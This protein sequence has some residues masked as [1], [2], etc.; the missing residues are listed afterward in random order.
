MAYVLL[1]LAL[2]YGL[3]Q[4]GIQPWHITAMAEKAAY[5]GEII[6]EGITD[7][8]GLQ[9]KFEIV[10]KQVAPSVVAISAACTK[11]EADAALRSEDMSVQKLQA[12]LDHTTRIV[13]SGFVIDSNGYILTNE[14]V[15]G[16]AEQIWV[17]TD[18]KKIYPAIVVGSD[19]RADLA[20]LKIPAR[21]LPV[22]RFADGGTVRGQWTIALGNPYGLAAEGEMAMSVGIVSATNR[23]LPKLASKENRLYTN[24]IQTTAQINP[25]NS[26]GPLFD[27]KGRVIG[28]NTAVILPQ[29]T[30]NGIGFAMPITDSLLERMRELKEG[31]ETVYGYLG[32]MIS[33]PTPR[34]RQVAGVHEVIGACIDS[35]EPDS[36]AVAAK[37]LPGDLVT[38][39][40]GQTIRDGDHL[41]R[42]VGDAPVDKPLLMSVSREGKTL[43][44]TVT[45]RRRQLPSVAVSKQRQRLRW[46]GMVLGPVPEHWNV[47]D[48]TNSTK[49]QKPSGIMVYGI[50]STSDFVKQG[51]TTGTV[52]TAIAGQSISDMLALQKVLNDTPAEQCRLEL[53]RSPKAVATVGE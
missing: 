35:F 27:L 52:I 22:V 14:H 33:T 15:V 37:L 16:E 24:L 3:S 11:A 53:Y 19:P 6:D 34:Q 9:D 7:L 43:G 42:L 40:N 41:V 49:D 4:S 10:A 21:N 1:G 5:A 23:S 12:I 50:E 47:N 30:T 29:K 18:D 51:I 28:V 36:P 31:R 46:Q 2:G 26:G 39:F 45:L 32:A 44:L 48:T 8:G 13:G 38:K 25:G 20:V 17:T